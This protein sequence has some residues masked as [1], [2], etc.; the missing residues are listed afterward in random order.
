MTA[1]MT[2]ADTI[3]LLPLLAATRRHAPGQNWVSVDGGQTVFV[4]PPVVFEPDSITPS[5]WFR[6]VGTQHLSSGKVAGLRMKP[7]ARA[8]DHRGLPD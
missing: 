1:S 7:S 6:T 4:R 3:L 2:K 8:P 5:A